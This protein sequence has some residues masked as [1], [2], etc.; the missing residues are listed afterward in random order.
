MGRRAVAIVRTGQSGQ[1]S[2]VCDVRD[3][4]CVLLLEDRMHKTSA[5]F[6]FGRDLL[7]QLASTGSPIDMRVANNLG[8]RMLEICQ[9][10]G[11]YDS[12][13]FELEDGRLGFMA[14]LAFTNQSNR[15]M[16]VVNV[17]LRST[18]IDDWFEWLIPREFPFITK[19]EEKTSN[20]AYAFPGRLGLQLPFDD[21]LNHILLEE[22]V[23]SPKRPVEGWLLGVGGLIPSGLLNG[24]QIDVLIT[25][26]ASDH[27]EYTSPLHLFVE[28]NPS[29]RRVVKRTSLFEQTTPAASFSLDLSSEPREDDHSTESERSSRFR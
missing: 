25:V 21:V 1:T 27:S 2:R 6:Q 19:A 28:R 16:Y 7:E 10:G 5:E 26:I 20:Q 15:A 11:Y 3:A 4:R 14:D 17:E 12:K 22:G 24:R 8:C 13:I 9:T 29:P 23:L 18:A